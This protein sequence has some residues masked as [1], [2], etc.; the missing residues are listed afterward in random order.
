MVGWQKLNGSFHEH[1]WQARFWGGGLQK[2]GGWE[3]EFFS[4]AIAWHEMGQ[5]NLIGK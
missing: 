2:G 3:K 5:T 1:V 4:K